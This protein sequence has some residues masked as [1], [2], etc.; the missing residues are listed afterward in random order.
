MVMVVTR[1]RVTHLMVDKDESSDATAD[2]TINLSSRS[3]VTLDQKGISQV[4]MTKIRTL[5]DTSDEVLRGLKALG[6]E[7]T[8]KDPWS[9]QILMQKLDTETK[10][11]WSVKTAEKDF[12][13]LNEFLEFLNVRCSSL[14]LMTCND[15]DT[16]VPTKSNFK[17]N[18]RSRSDKNCLK[19]SGKHN[20]LLHEDSNRNSAFLLNVNANCKRDADNTLIGSVG[21]QEISNIELDAVNTTL[22]SSTSVNA[23]CV[24]FLPTAKVL[25]YN[26]EGGSFLFRALLDSGSESSFISENAI[27]ILGLNR[28]FLRGISGIQA[29]TTHGSVGLKIGS[30]FC[31]DQLTIKAYIL[32]K[33]T[34]QIPVERVNIKELDYLEGFSGCE[35]FSK[36]SEC[37]IIL[38]SDCFFSILRNGRITGSKGHPI[39]QSTIFGWVVADEEEFCENHFKA[40]Y[41]INESR[42][43]VKLPIYRDINQLGNTRG[44]LLATRN[45]EPWSSDVDDKKGRFSS[46]QITC[47]TT[48]L[49][50]VFDGSCKPPNSNSL[51]SVLGVGQ[52]LQPDIFTLL[53]RFRVNEIAFT[54]D[55]KQMYR[56]ILID[57]DDQNL[58]KIVRRK[59]LD[60]NIKEYKL[61]T[62]T[63]GTAS[64]S[65]LATRYLH[66][67]SL[68]CEP[69]NPELS[70]I[71]QS[72]FYVDD[73]MSG[74][75]F[76]KE[77][78]ILIKALIQALDVCARGF[79][80]RKWRSNSRDVL[81][82]ISKNLEFD[83]PNVEIHPENCSK[84]LGLIWDSKEDRFIFNI[85]FKFEGEITKRSFSPNQ[86]DFLT[87]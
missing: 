58:Q 2:L 79:H 63:Y 60:S 47:I 75:S 81:I 38:G 10:R 9:I 64:A 82:N 1:V 68:D 37:D 71:I 56:Q 67:I 26:N 45:F 69:Q 15:S 29:G 72:S 11:L 6:T 39:A 65:F 87:L 46:R 12:P 34:S 36:P 27:N 86:Q 23:K 41:K 30:R 40:T 53:V 3:V 20:Y 44:S 5:A 50:V 74:A 24:S 13:T 19:C 21:Q 31:K 80:L 55:I 8:N 48:K 32:N 70:S 66:Q 22:N 57:P 14:E 7:A 49:R 16:K 54:A 61:S 35:D 18:P 62:V 83:E 52:I 17:N 59:S 25:L 85:N 43:V 51:N 33:V 76:N 78:I 77:A 84:A 4:N 28:L 73:L 42:F